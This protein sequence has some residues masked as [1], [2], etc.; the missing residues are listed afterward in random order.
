[1]NLKSHGKKLQTK[2]IYNC[3]S[4]A[5]IAQLNE[6]GF[7]A[8]YCGVIPD[9]LE[10]SIDFIKSLKKYDV[11][12][13]SGGISMGDADF[14]AEAFLKN[15]L[16][17]AFH[18]VKCKT[19]SSYNDGENVILLVICLPG[20]PLTA[21]VNINLFVIPMLKKLQGENAFYHGYIKS[22]KSK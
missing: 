22:Y 21:M 17:V 10:K 2:K 20:N 8:T 6:K 1:M 16:E 18:G 15:G 13:T 19:R 12:I 5:I 7:N 11:I 3:N 4:F 14:M 9:N